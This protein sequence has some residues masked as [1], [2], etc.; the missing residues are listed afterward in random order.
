MKKL[1][2]FLL[3]LVLCTAMACPV[4]AADDAVTEGADSGFT[5]STEVPPPVDP[6]DPGDSDLD[7]PET[8]DRSQESTLLLAGI[9]GLS[10][11]GIVVVSAILWKN[12]ESSEA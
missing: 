9:M 1:I 4:F 6:D 5:Q 3:A 11:V 8:G 10:F 7:V 12:R 2:A